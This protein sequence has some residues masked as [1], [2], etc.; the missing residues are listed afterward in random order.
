TGGFRRDGPGLASACGARSRKRIA[1]AERSGAP[2]R[3]QHLSARTPALLHAEPALHVLDGLAR[4]GADLA[5]HFADV[6]AAGQEQALQL[7]ALGAGE[8]RIVGRPGGAD[9]GK[10]LQAVAED[11]DGKAVGFGGVVG[12]ERV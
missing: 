4:L 5:V 2:E 8:R 9:A 11:R 10:A 1:A 3:L 12:I 7:A 6:V